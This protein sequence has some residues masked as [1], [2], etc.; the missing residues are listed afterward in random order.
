MA[1]IN[2]DEEGENLKAVCIRF[3]LCL[4]VSICGYISPSK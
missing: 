4:S 3:D 2:T 1:Q